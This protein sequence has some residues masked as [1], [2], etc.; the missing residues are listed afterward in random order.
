MDERDRLMAEIS[1]GFASGLI[2][3]EDLRIFL[4]RSEDHQMTNITDDSAAVLSPAEVSGAESAP[5]QDVLQRK[6]SEES[7]HNKLSAVEIL[8]YL[9]GGVLYASLMAMA[10][11]TG[12][13]GA[14]MR[15]G[16]LL[17]SG[18]GLW[19]LVYYLG[20]RNNDVVSENRTG[21]INAML[22][23]GCLALISGGVMAA[24]EST[25]SDM[26]GYALAL[27]FLILGGLHLFFDSIFR[28][29][30]LVFLGFILLTAAFPT[31]LLTLLG[32]S[33]VSTDVRAMI[34]V[35]TGGLLAAAG[36]IASR[37]VPRREGLKDSFLSLAG[38]IVLASVYAASLT[39]RVAALWSIVL[40]LLIFGAFYVSIQRRSKNFLVTGSVFLVMY[41]MTI[42]FKYFSGFGAAFSLLLSATAL[43]GTAFMAAS[44]NKRYIISD[45]ES[46]TTFHPR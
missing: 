3:R 32:S 35:A 27:A 41:V 15:V 22:L 13:N 11:Q 26:F 16:I 19:A 1:E 37:T 43:L 17:V 10:A 31:L 2:S 45:D 8:F 38:F 14:A 42:A 12:E 7:V 40:P 39:S 36:S 24:V 33:E 9:A 21:F 4:P 23:T 20:R 29:I 34:G 5:R 30:I 46:K 18:F 6:V 28:R 44:L 25:S